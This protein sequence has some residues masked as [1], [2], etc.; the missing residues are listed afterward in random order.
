MLSAAV[1]EQVEQ[2]TRQ[3]GHEMF[4]RMRAG[5]PW[6]TQSEWWQDRLLARCTANEWFKVQSFRFIDALPT[7]R[8]DATIARHIQEYFAAP[9]TKKNGRDL[10]ELAPRRSD[11]LVSCVS[12]AST[13]AAP[14][15]IAGSIA[16]WVA[17]SGALTM[18]NKFIAGSNVQ[19]AV[20]TIEKMRDKGLAFTVDVL[21]EAALS[22]AE[23]QHY[24]DV[25]LKLI[26]ELPRFAANW[27]KTPLVDEADGEPI[28]RVNVSVKVTS[29]HSGFDAIAPDAA[30]RRAKEMLRPLLRKGMEAGAHVHIDMEHHAIKDL[31]LELFRELMVE[32][33]FRDYPHFGIV[34]QAYLKDADRDA[35][36]MIEFAKQRGTP[37]WVRLVK[38]AYWDSETVWAAQAGWPVPVWEQKWQSDACYERVMGALLLNH[39]YVYTALGSHNIRSLSYGRALKQALDIPDARFEWQMLYGMGDPIKRAAV[40]IGQRCRVYTPYG[41]IMPGMAYLIRRLLENTANE[42]FLRHSN[43]NETPEDELLR[44]PVETGKMSAPPRPHDV[45][46]YEFGKLLMSTFENT[47]DTD[48]GIASNRTRMLD[49]LQAARRRFGRECPL[50]IGQQRVSTGQWRNSVNPCRPS[51]IVA[52]AADAGTGD[53]DRAV[54]A[55][56][57]AFASW[58]R[59]SATE[60]VELLDRVALEM[61]ERRFDLAATLVFES[62]KP[63]READAEVS[64]AIDCCRYAAAEM[65]RLSAHVRRRDIPGET[66]E[67]FYVPR[68]V[69]AVIAPWN[70][71]L[72]TLSGMVFAAIV[73][74]NT[75]VAKPAE[76]T[77]GIAYQLVELCEAAGLPA[78]VLNYLPG[79][80][81]VVGEHLVKHPH[82]ATI[83]FTGSKAVGL[84]VNRVAAE[85]LTAAPS[86][87]RVIAEMGGKNAI[88]VDGDADQDEAT[89]AV[90][91]GA[92]GFAGQKCSA[93]SRVIILEDLYD[94]FAARL[95]EA[96]RVAVGP[97]EEPTT[98]VNALIDEE[99]LNTVREYVR[100]G[101][102][103]GRL[104]LEVDVPEEAKRTGGFYV[105]PVI[106]GDVPATARIAR[107]EI[108]GP[109][110]ALQ[111]ARDIQHSIELFNT[112]DF[113]LTGGIFSRS[114]ANIDLA[115]EECICGNFYINRRVTGARIDV[116]PFGGHKLSGT[117]QKVGGPDYLIQ[118]CDAKSVSE[119]TLR[120]GFAPSD[121]VA[122]AVK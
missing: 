111:R 54:A 97:A 74:G 3:L 40:E 96:A 10:D 14:R 47:P 9:P 110:L 81:D 84:R 35:A 93:V 80:G 87:K 6:P 115:R 51:E 102:T 114:P 88:I 12:W 5:R 8:D 2:R 86:V 50:V 33:E 28:P 76:Q 39:R 61:G 57:E 95:V 24:F 70:F 49:A 18:A 94:R 37:L 31:T 62:G 56:A 59:T 113:A 103:E 118:F 58:R 48:F 55:A 16:A 13:F 19:Q 104:L 52:K 46:R 92:F 38:G 122:E 117:G 4:E 44:D 101:K 105:G 77:P 23:S 106:F 41:D 112:G 98:Y 45:R 36:E 60:R 34:L 66:N 43:N 75:V 83:A 11:A 108:F 32:P 30:K 71:P 109:V 67:Y 78:G 29:L 64:K 68:G 22:R 26:S 65:R 99:Q 21:G 90:I 27:R 1:A 25:Y 89:K 20:R 53:A 72:S 116:Q 79:A 7:M 121:E 69:T 120:R 91:S 119:N 100:I 85:T 17:R 107:E 73:T 15:S 63:W 42:S 82:V